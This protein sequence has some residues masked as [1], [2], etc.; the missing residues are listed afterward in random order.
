VPEF[1]AFILIV[2]C[3]C[4]AE[5]ISDIFSSDV[6]MKVTLYNKMLTDVEGG[7]GS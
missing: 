7:E 2:F 3:N 6:L 5:A 1:T 4:F